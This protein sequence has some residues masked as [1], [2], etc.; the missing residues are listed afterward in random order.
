MNRMDFITKEKIE[1]GW[2]MDEKYCVTTPDGKKYL[3]RISPKEKREE[4]LMMFRLLK[5]L[6]AVGVSMC[7]PID[8]FEEDI[9]IYTLFTWI[10]GRDAEE[11]IPFLSEAEQYCYGFEAGKI[12]K[13]IHTLPAPENLPDWEILFNAK[14]DRKIKLYQECPIKFDGSEMVISY[15]EANRKLL[16]NRPQTFQHGDF[17]IGNMM[18]EKG[19]L[20]IIDFDRYDF[21]DP[22]EEF[23][24]IVFCAEASP[25]FASGIVNGYFDDEVPFD[26]WKLLA[27][28]IS[29]NMLSSIPWAINFG[30]K[31]IGTMLN[32]A[33]KVMEWYN[34]FENVIP[35]WYVKK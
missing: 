13:T 22:W 3:L 34:Y 23:N 31:E 9:G 35:S 27:L 14:M 10:E 30:E 12:L 5:Q 26:F 25:F 2:S 4:R 32:Q 33:M 11:I 29:S 19:K 6:S 24:R 17:H 21:G 16:A 8:Y 1:K 7:Q 28:Y 20:I 18:F 15:I